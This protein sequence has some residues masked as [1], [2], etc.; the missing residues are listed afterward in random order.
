MCGRFT[1]MLQLDELREQLALGELPVELVPNPNITPGQL[2]PVVVDSH[3]RNVELYKWGLV[4]GWA[5]D[6]NVGFK[7][8][9]ARAETLAE[10]PSFRMPFARQRCLILADGFYEWKSDGQKKHPYLFRLKEE[11]AFTFAGLWEK[12]RDPE[13]KELKSCAIIT[14][15]PNS[16]VANYHDRMP[17]IL[18]A[19]SRWMWL[20]SGSPQDLERLLRPFPAELMSEPILLDRI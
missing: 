3:K 11:R 10:K 2:I 19:E 6:P 20:E 4:P 13:G 5:K 17:V 7:M 8:I 16:L 9:N 18:G 12:W 14:T 1:I 15:S